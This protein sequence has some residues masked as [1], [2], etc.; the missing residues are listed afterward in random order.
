MSN[1]RL[2]NIMN[3]ADESIDSF[4]DI[5]VDA[6][7][8]SD[9]KFFKLGKAIYKIAHSS[10]NL[11]RGERESNEF[12]NFKDVLKKDLKKLKKSNTTDERHLRELLKNMKILFEGSTLLD[13][14]DKQ[15]ELAEWLRRKANIDYQSELP[16]SFVKIVMGRLT[17]LVTAE[18]WSEYISNKLNQYASETNQCLKELIDNGINADNKLDTIINKLNRNDSMHASQTLTK[19]GIKDDS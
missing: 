13:Y 4:I 17:E 16:K 15:D 6:L 10:I 2:D 5:S 11:V 14:F 7:A 12:L 1:N 9:I 19:S 3:L 8:E 18:E